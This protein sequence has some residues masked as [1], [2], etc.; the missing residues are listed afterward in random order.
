[1]G[2]ASNQGL[3]EMQNM[4][5]A[6]DPDYTTGDHDGFAQVI[7]LGSMFAAGPARSTRL[8]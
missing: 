4:I 7:A 3:V 2:G 8:F 5:P 6:A 1:M